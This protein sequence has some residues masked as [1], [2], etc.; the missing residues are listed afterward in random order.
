MYVLQV[1]GA[2]YRLYI[3]SRDYNKGWKALQA[4][5]GGGDRKEE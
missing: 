1:S 2:R 4:M 3:I 5:S